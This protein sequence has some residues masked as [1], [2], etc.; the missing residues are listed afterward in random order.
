M[1]YGPPSD[2]EEGIKT[3]QHAYELGVNFF[4]TAELY[5]Y[6]HNEKLV[7]SAVVFVKT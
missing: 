7:G 2:E 5:G 3:I 1:A 4:D 6:G